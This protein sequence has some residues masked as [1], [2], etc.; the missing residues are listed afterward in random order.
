MNRAAFRSGSHFPLFPDG[1]H[2]ALIRPF[3]I[4]HSVVGIDSGVWYYHPMTDHFVNLDRDDHRID[5]AYLA[6]EQPIAAHASAVCFLFANLNLLLANGG[7]DLYR[8]AHLEAGMIAQRLYIAANSIGLGCAPIGEFY[9][10]EVRKFLGMEHT[11]WE[12]IHA[13]VVGISTDDRVVTSNT[14]ELNEDDPWRD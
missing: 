6:Y 7:P 3:W 14:V 13:V 9:D 1:P 8:L 5:A 10:D 11:G 12:P 4:I 2:V